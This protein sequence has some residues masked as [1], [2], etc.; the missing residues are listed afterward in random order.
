MGCGHV[1]GGADGPWVDV[2]LMSMTTCNLSSF[3]LVKN[4]S[5]NALRRLEVMYYLCAIS[6]CC[7]SKL[8]LAEDR[9]STFNI[10]VPPSAPV[11]LHYGNLG[12]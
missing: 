11:E 12:F 5:M 10:Q 8:L 7:Q 9:R 4:N 2:G 1:G 3:Y 6:V